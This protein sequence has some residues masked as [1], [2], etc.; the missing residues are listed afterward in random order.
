M[1][2]IRTSTGLGVKKSTMHAGGDDFSGVL[3]LEANKTAEPAT[4]A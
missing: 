1:F 2:I 3:I 4:V